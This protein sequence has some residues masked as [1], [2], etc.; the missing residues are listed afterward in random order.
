[1]AKALGSMVRQPRLSAP[2][3]SLVGLRI[4]TLQCAIETAV[5]R[6]VLGADASLLPSAHPSPLVIGLK[7]HAGALLPVV[8]L[9]RW[10]GFVSA[11]TAPPSRPRWVVVHGLEGPFAVAADEVSG[12]FESVANDA[13]PVAIF[14]AGALVRR[15]LA[16]ARGM[17]LELDVDTI[18]AA[19]GAARATA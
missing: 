10:P 8:D 17:A 6:G 11:E 12:V 13:R 7:E 3:R 2:A 15:G 9:R 16:T 1:V 19:L 14:T 4:G 18:A 5:V